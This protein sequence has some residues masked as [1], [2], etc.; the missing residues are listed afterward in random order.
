MNDCLPSVE[1]IGDE[2]FESL[3]RQSPIEP[4]TSRFESITLDQAYRISQRILQR[5]LDE[6]EHIVGKKIGVTSKVVQ[7]MLGVRQPDFGFLTDAMQLT[8]GSTVHIDRT[9]IQPRAEGEIAFLLKSDLKGPDLSSDDVREATEMIFPCIEIV[10]SRIRDWRIQIEDTVADN[11]SC[12][13]FVLG[14]KGAQLDC[15]DPAQLTARLEKNGELLSTGKGDA[16]QG[17]PLNAVAWLA[18]KLADYGIALH[19]GEVVLSGALVPLEPAVTGDRFTFFLDGVG[20]CRV[21]FA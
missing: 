3:R 16:V 7:E 10:D 18:N 20:S 14:E 2:L 15:E 13:A 6:G 17:S 9:F 8:D 12:G 5:R 4:L 1:Q 19:A 21:Q 11:A